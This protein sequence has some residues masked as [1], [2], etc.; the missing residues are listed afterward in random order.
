MLATQLSAYGFHGLHGKV[1]AAKLESWN[2]AVELQLVHSLALILIA[3]L[4]TLVP[5]STLLRI[6]GALMIAGQLLFC[7]S[8]YADVLGAPAGINQVAPLG[9]G[10]FM[11]GWLLT[12]VAGFRLP[13][14]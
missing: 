14:N 6:A 11:L 10:S 1:A 13:K 7:A 5:R 4:L 9:G 2:W 12:A 8:V 3:L